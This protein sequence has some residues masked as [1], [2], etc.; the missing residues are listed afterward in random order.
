YLYA[1]VLTGAPDY[2]QQCIFHGR[3][4]PANDGLRI[5]CAQVRLS[6]FDGLY[7]LVTAA[8][9]GLIG[10]S[11]FGAAAG[12]LAAILFAIFASMFEVA[13]YGGLPDQH[14]LLPL[15]LAYGATFRFDRVGHGRWLV[16]A[17]ALGAFAA[18]FK[19]TG[20]LDLAAICAYL[21]VRAL[22]DHGVRGG[23]A[24]AVRTCALVA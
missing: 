22:V 5:A 9:V 15:A 6:A 21:I 18:L 19:Q 17:G 11:L 4:F 8:V 24:E 14:I 3:P 23:V 10:R 16:L 20:V 2:A 12:W 1:A 7:A 13:R